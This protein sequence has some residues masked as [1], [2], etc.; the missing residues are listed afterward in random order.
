[1][2][3]LLTLFLCF[4][5]FQLMA[6]DTLRVLFLGNSYTN[7]IP[8]IVQSIADSQGKIMEHDRHTLGGYTLQEH[9]VDATGLAKIAL[10]NWDY[11]VIQEQSQLP[12]FSPNQVSTQ[13]YPYAA[14]LANSIRVANPCTQPIF[15]MTWG[16][17]NGDASNCEFY[18]PLCTYEGMQERLT[19]S[20]N[21]M[22]MDNDALVAPVGETWRRVRTANPDFSL[23]NGDGSHPNANGAYLAS[24][25]FYSMFYEGSMEGDY[26]V[27]NAV[28]DEDAEMIRAM[29]DETV[30]DENEQWDFSIL[31]V[32]AS[33][34]YM[35]EED[36][37]SFTELST[38]AT[39]HN[40]S[41]GDGNNSSEASPT[42]LYTSSG[43]YE[44]TYIASNDCTADT[45]TL[46]I[47]YISTTTEEL[48]AKDFIVMPNPFTSSI[49]IETNIAS[50][51]DVTIYN[52]LGKRI[53][54]LRFSNDVEVDLSDL[55]R[56]AYFLGYSNEGKSNW[57]KLLRE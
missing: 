48:I 13:V 11:V 51:I 4:A 23:Y 3:Q 15:Y 53:K 34:E 1:M 36:L 14:S 9:S 43:I 21:E 10:G 33:A 16:R 41:F 2:K 47:N 5:M 46:E 29:A 25:V 17:E 49:R 19:E 54:T 39:S 45:I 40:W 56:G 52:M 27:T 31:E 22:A 24:C 7:N 42:Y 32:M 50:S 35:L 26:F 37:F 38:N 12:S 6:Q 44:V 57:V 30:F 18:E 20:Y 8:N 55:P 28:L